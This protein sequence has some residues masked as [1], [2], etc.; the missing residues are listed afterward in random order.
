M[1]QNNMLLAHIDDLAVK[2]AKTGCA[3]SRFLTPAEALSTAT[4]LAKRRDVRIVFDGGYEGAERVRAVLMHPDRGEYDRRVLFQVL[5]I[6][7]PPQEAIGHRD[8]L[9]AA[10]A[11]GIERSAIGDIVE[12]PVALICVP[13]MR[14]YIIDNLTT[15]GRAHVKLSEMDVS[16]ISAKAE[17]LRVKTDTIASPRLDAVLGSAFGLSRGKAA[18]LIAAG[19][20]NLDHEICQHPAKEVREGAILSVRGLGRAKLLEISGV[21]KKGRLFIKL[22]LYKR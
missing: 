9:G 17:D 4:Y 22:G 2:A 15:I 11:L 18:E 12:S 6:D 10:M 21:S 14:A 8:I 1:E 13:E 16:E 5:R 19:N 3:A 7:A 20:V